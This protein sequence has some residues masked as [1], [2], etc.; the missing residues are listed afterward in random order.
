LIS[1]ALTVEDSGS[2]GL[3]ALDVSIGKTGD[4]AIAGSGKPAASSFSMMP[5]AVSPSMTI[6]DSH[7]MPI[8]PGADPYLIL[9]EIG[10]RF[11]GRRSRRGH[12]TLERRPATSGRPVEN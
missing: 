1:P 6:E 10:R 3:A 4:G 9:Y 12:P 2:S 11:A 8:S 7:L 5:P